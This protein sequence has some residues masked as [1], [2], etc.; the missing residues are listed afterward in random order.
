MKPITAK[1]LIGKDEDLP[2]VLKGRTG[3]LPCQYIEL[4][5]HQGIV[6]SQAALMASQF[7]PVSLDLRLGR[8][9]YRI[10]CSFLPENETVEE[11]LKDLTL[12]EVDLTGDGGILEKGAIYLIPLLEELDLPPTIYGR[13]NPKSSTGRLDMFTRVIVDGGHRFDEIPEGYK[14][15]M[16][17]EII[18]RSFPVKVRENLALN[19]LRFVHGPQKI[20]GKSSLEPYYRQHPI[21]FD[22]KGA[23]IPFDKVKIDSGLFISVELSTP[24]P[25]AVIAYKAKTNSNVIDL[26]KLKHYDPLDFWEPLRL[27]PGQKNRLVL[28]PESFYIMMSKEKIS[29]APDLLAEM[30]AYEPNSG[31]LR[32]HYAG[33]FD[34][35]FG[36]REGAGNLA[37][38]TRAVMEVRPHDVPFMVEDGQT[39]C[40]LK[41]EKV[42]ETPARIYGEQIHS[43]YQN[44]ELTLSKYFKNPA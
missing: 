15:K 13:T 22:S 25:D 8:K 37:Q 11:R 28:E 20:F 16:Y 43:N 5:A 18:P 39:F 27:R 34:P 4:A 30:V 29:I 38:G 41:F 31:E 32:T 21:L 12:Y 33:F 35:G 6:H 14:G 1:S 44:Q 3:Y 36:W 26:S 19:Q 42:I 24:S 2:G 23:E 10:Q 7:Q 17:L 40:R 9:G